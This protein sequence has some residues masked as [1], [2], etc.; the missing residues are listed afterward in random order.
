VRG[1]G[2]T[3]LVSKKA[4]FNGSGGRKGLGERE[5]L[6][7]GPWASSLSAWGGGGKEGGWKIFQPVC[8][9]LKKGS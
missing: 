8:C 1:G 6:L 9:A 5:I 7:L 3:L 2:D 4:F